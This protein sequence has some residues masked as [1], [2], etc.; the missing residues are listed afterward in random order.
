[1]ND[2]E[3]CEDDDERGVDVDNERRRMGGGVGMFSRLAVT[4]RGVTDVEILRKQGPS[5]V[6]CRVRIQGT[7]DGGNDLCGALEVLPTHL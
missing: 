4:S 5:L 2:D 6:S 1:M 7:G 3:D